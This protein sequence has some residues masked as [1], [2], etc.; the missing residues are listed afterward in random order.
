[1]NGRVLDYSFQNDSGT[2]VGSDGSRYTFTGVQWQARET[3]SPGM[4]VTFDADG[5]EAVSV[6][7][8]AME[9]HGGA[10]AGAKSRGTAALLAIFLGAFC[11]H[12]F[13]LGRYGTAISRLLLYPAAVMVGSPVGMK[14]WP[15]PFLVITAI[16]LGI[17]GLINGVMLLVQSDED[18]YQKYVADRTS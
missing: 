9:A 17:F 5:A 13:Y 6:Y 12:H 18:F 10:S 14:W 15:L 7:W 2:I 1:M 4:R 3:P 8:L 16:I 11:A